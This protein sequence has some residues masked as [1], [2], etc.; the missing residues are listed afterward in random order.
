MS[1]CLAPEADGNDVMQ[2]T[3]A[4]ERTNQPA[5]SGRRRRF[6]A[7]GVLAA[8]GTTVVVL[9]SSGSAL[10]GQYTVTF[11][12]HG[13]V[14]PG[15]SIWTTTG[16]TSSFAVNPPCSGAPLGFSAGGIGSKVAAGTR[17]GVQYLVLHSIF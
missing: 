6:A 1:K 10:A 5:R 3:R 15:C 11:D 8:F 9:A 2:E 4:T 12:A 13:N 17:F 14:Q 7:V 16:S